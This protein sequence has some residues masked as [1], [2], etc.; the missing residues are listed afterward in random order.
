ME[1]GIVSS[2]EPRT[3][4]RVWF[5]PR[6]DYELTLARLEA[7][8]GISIGRT[9]TKT[10]TNADEFVMQPKFV[11]S[12]T[13]RCYL[14]IRAILQEINGEKR[15]EKTKDYFIVSNSTVFEINVIL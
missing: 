9:V 12:Q 8:P 4:N 2:N 14:L 13:A 10:V 1:I 7:A 15:P 6:G 11:L 5:L 3:I